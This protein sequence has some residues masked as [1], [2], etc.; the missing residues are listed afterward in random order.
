VTGRFRL[1]ALGTGVALAMALPAALVAQVLEAVQ[2]DGD[3]P[4][5]LTYVLA[6][7]VL[8]G[9]VLGGTTVGRPRPSRPA[10][11][12]AVCG[13]VAVLVVLA[14]GVTRRLVAG[15]HVAWGTVPITAVLATALAAASSALAARV[16][17]RKRP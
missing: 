9:M 2:D 7:V 12:G 8:A 5:A 13:L 17:G 15:D 10:L 6:I 1:V 3:D 14:L 4:G 16:P 11:L